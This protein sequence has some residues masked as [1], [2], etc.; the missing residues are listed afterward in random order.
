MW[1]LVALLLLRHALSLN[2]GD[3]ED[4]DDA[5]ALFS[6]R[7]LTIEFSGQSVF[8]FSFLLWA[9]I[10]CSFAAVLASSCWVSSS[11]LYHGLGYQHPAASQTTTGPSSAQNFS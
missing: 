2:S 1:Q 3:S 6:V 8:F 5:S 9:F 4:E 11:L 10:C 7:S